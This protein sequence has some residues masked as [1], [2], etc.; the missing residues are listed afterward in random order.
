MTDNSSTVPNFL[1][2]Q[3]LV[4][5]GSGGMFTVS[6]L[7]LGGLLSLT[8]ETAIQ[9]PRPHTRINRAENKVQ[10]GQSVLEAAKRH[11]QP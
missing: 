10:L 8:Q 6:L 4:Y 2:A 11:E 7:R 1:T 5:A 3:I 9:A